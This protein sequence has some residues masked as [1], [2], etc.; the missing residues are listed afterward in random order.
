MAEFG[1]N[2]AS[3]DLLSGKQIERL[4]AGLNT[5]IARMPEA[6]Q[7]TDALHALAYVWPSNRRHRDALWPLMTRL[8][9]FADDVLPER[10][11][12][13]AIRESAV[14]LKDRVNNQ[15]CDDGA[16][17]LRQVRDLR[18]VWARERAR[19]GYSASA[20]ESPRVR[21]IPQPELVVHPPRLNRDSYLDLPTPFD[22]L[23]RPAKEREPLPNR[24]PKPWPWP[25]QEPKP[26]YLYFEHLCQQQRSATVTPPQIDENDERLIREWGNGVLK[27]DSYEFGRLSSARA[28]EKGLAKLYES[29]GFIV[30]DVSLGQLGDAA[31]RRWQL[32]DLLVDG[33]PVDVK[34]SRYSSCKRPDGCADYVEHCVPAFKNARWG[35]P[36]AI[37]GVVSPYIPAKAAADFGNHEVQFLGEVRKEKL[38]QIR[39]YFCSDDLLV[40]DFRRAGRQGAFLPPWVFEY[41]AK[42]YM[43][44]AGEGPAH[45]RL[46]ISEWP[47]CDQLRTA[48]FSPLAALATCQMTWPEHWPRAGFDDVTVAFVERLIRASVHLGRSRP[49]I[50]VAILRFVLELMTEP[51][52]IRNWSPENLLPV[53]YLRSRDSSR[54]LDLY[55]PLETISSLLTVLSRTWKYF[56]GQSVGFN[57]FQVVS[58]AILRARAESTDQWKTIMAY[59]GGWKTQEGCYPDGKR[60]RCGRTPLYLG[61]HEVCVSCS[62]LI[63]DVCGFCAS[64]CQLVEGHQLEADQKNRQGAWSGL[65]NG[66]RL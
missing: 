3:L 5:L 46:T 64:S 18:Q 28:A 1:R 42:F 39:T 22:V 7:L 47:S 14:N 38:D 40:I 50:W 58:G 41:P 61:M 56:E 43:S 51:N 16:A 27:E 32:Y 55:D 57:Q 17:F 15:S 6:K 48:G 9:A 31:N 63:C 66:G 21:A 53:I 20:G 54:P 45:D 2:G 25:A 12:F 59:C 24:Q 26:W 60:V 52:R 30:E 35:K 4:V 34:N 29:H 37:A 8:C 36:V 13:S 49:V 62:H 23:D 65:E 10:S 19:E 11:G 33:Q 44:M